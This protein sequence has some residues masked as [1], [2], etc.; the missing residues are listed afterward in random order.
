MNQLIKLHINGEEH[1]LAVDPADTLLK[2]LRERAGLQGTKRGCDAGGCGCCTVLVD[3][4]AVYSCMTFAM[5]AQGKAVTTVEGLAQGEELDPIQAAFIKAGAVQCGYCTCGMMMSAKELLATHADPDEAT[6]R[7][8][9]A[10]NLCRCTGYQKIVDAIKL[11]A[12]R[13]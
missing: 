4:Q 2:A 13:P 10:G 1:E 11:A 12:A 8:G 6:I 7:H 5:S 9:I 3:G